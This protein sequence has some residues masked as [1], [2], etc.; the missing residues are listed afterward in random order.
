METPLGHELPTDGSAQQ[1]VSMDLMERI[2]K[3]RWLGM[4]DEAERL[5]MQLCRTPLVSRALAVHYDD[6][7]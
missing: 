5:Q 2:R 1:Q 6:T 4:E 7:D 3:L